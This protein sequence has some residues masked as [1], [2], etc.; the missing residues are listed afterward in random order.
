MG[1]TGIIHIRVVVLNDQEEL[2][3]TV[4]TSLSI[5]FLT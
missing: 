5:R 2:H 3:L 4:R 1:Y